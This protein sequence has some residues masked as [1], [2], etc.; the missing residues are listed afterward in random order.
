MRHVG[1]LFARERGSVNVGVAV[2]NV[3]TEF[4]SMIAAFRWAQPAGPNNA[5]NG[6]GPARLRPRPT[7]S[8]RL[9]DGSTTTLA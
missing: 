3:G 1:A 5:K 6:R 7:H 9:R 4:R 2:G 8:T